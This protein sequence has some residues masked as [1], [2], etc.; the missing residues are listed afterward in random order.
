MEKKRVYLDY[1]AS[2]PLHPLVLEQVPQWLDL[3][4]NPSSIHWAGRMAKSKLS[5]ARNQIAHCLGVKPTEL[6]FTSG[7]TEANNLAIKGLI[8]KLK[9]KKLLIGSA[10]HPSLTQ[11]AQSITSIAGHQIDLE[12]IPYDPHGEIDL[13]AYEKMLHSSNKPIGL[14]SV[15]MVQNETGAIAPIKK[16]AKM[17]HQAGAL[18]HSDAVQALGKMK[19][20]LSHLDIDLATF[21]AHKF[22]SLKGCGILYCRQGTVELIPQIEGGRGERSRR[23]GTENLL[24]I[25]SMGYMCS[26]NEFHYQSL[27]EIEA[28]SSYFEKKV[29][30][31]VS[32]IKIVAH[33]AKKVPGVFTIVVQ[34]VSGESLLMKL[35]IDGIAVSMGSACNSGRTEPSLSLQA[36]GLSKEEASTAIRISFGWG[37]THEDID[38]FIDALRKNVNYLRSCDH[39]SN[40]A[41]VVTHVS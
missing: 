15:M 3:W 12:L 11:A 10:E 19:F 23:A 38:F 7:G 40:N 5:H 28:L 33:S 35:D 25:A 31:E 22:Y 16:M 37:T 39:L 20:N 13:L 4:G 29:L 18:F 34:G 17:A 24:A 8:E 21:S 36:M 32:H 14:V 41:S 30:E 26:M 1:N 2:T 9:G 6:I 27:L